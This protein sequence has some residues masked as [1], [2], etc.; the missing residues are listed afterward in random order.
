[1]YN[2][3]FKVKYHDI[4]EELVLKLKDKTGKEKEKEK[5]KE[6]NPKVNENSDDTEDSEYE[7]SSQDVID[8]CHKL[9]IDEFISVF[10]CENILDDKIDLGMKY[11]FDKMCMNPEFKIIIE[12]MSQIALKTFSPNNDYD[13]EK[14]LDIKQ[15]IILT[16]FSQQ[17]F[18]IMH[19]CVCQQIE[20][21]TIDN[22]LLIQM[23][24]HSIDILKNQSPNI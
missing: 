10:N 9:Y 18:Y 24:A 13:E 5:E 16:L 20:L 6:A 2:T 23:K 3:Q 7:Y 8:I 11:V 15:L 22:E 1:M 4:E 17:T 12:E 14:L 21:G 19:K